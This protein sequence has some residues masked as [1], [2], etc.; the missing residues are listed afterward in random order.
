LDRAVISG[1]GRTSPT[2]SSM[3]H[4]RGEAEVAEVIHGSGLR[5]TISR[6][7]GRSYGDSAQNA[8]GL[9]LD[10]TG[11]TNV[12]LDRAQGRVTAEAG[13]SLD[14]LLKVLVPN[15]FFVPV[16][17]GTRFV[18]VGGA[19]AADVHGKNHHVDG[20]WGVHVTELR[21]L[22]STGS[23]LECSPTGPSA[24]AF[25]ATVGGMGLTGVIT[26]GSFGVL[27]IETSLMTVDTLKLDSLEGLM[28][29]MID[30]DHR[31]RYSVAWVDSLSASGRG[32]LTRGDHAPLSA[33][34]ASVGSPLAYVP[35]LRVSAP[36]WVPSGL[37][38]RATV[39]AF[40]AAWFRKAPRNRLGE[41]QSIPEFF[42]PLDG[43]R[44]WN[45]IYGS[46]G[47][48]QY[49]F[50]VPEAAGELVGIVLDRLRRAGAPNFLTVL[51]RFGAGN[52][53]PLSFPMAGWTLAADFPADVPG[54]GSVL[55][56]LDEL[57]LGAGGRFYLAKDSRMSRATFEAGYPRLP[58]WRKVR[59]ALDP[60][61]VF[62][63]DQARRLGLVE[64]G[65][66][67]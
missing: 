24:D 48:L 19:I 65:D 22:T 51:K 23:I 10:M 12:E 20:S 3:L 34:P 7:L 4:V 52:Q 29:E 32:V 44:G 5:G 58:E 42:H 6:G 50:A 18:T 60:R 45:R 17:P 62:M 56:E 25:W 13:S 37:L 38:N 9:V 59:D 36:P 43:V 15:G 54:L 49:Q 1:W 14:E 47:F 8:G 64:G 28:A 2:A 41:L 33:L 31:Y 63:S 26:Q 39:S 46:R 40:N 30:G 11:M 57:I 21:L 35:K 27:P 66:S 16:T 67:A 55:D 53:G 61:G